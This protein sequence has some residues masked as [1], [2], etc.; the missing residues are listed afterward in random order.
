MVIGIR[1]YVCVGE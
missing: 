1:W